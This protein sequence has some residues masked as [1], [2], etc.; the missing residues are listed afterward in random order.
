M[1]FT[2]F[3]SPSK[4]TMPEERTFPFLSVS[5]VFVQAGIGSPFSKDVKKVDETVCALAV[6]LNGAG[7]D[8]AVKPKQSRLATV[9]VK[10]FVLIE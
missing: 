5:A 2:F 4:A 6:R 1:V 8:G 9:I 10:I 3:P 7:K